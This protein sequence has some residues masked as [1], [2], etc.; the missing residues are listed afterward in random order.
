MCARRTNASSCLKPFEQTEN[1]HISRELSFEF[2]Y[3][4]M[5]KF[6]F[7]YLAK[8]VVVMPGGFGTLDELFELLTLI[9]TRKI[10]KHLPIVL[11]G[12]RYWSEVIDM[13]ALEKYGTID[14][15][16]L[17]LFFRTDSVDEAFDF[18]TEQLK[19]YSLGSPGATL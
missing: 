14:A 3:F 1:P 9:Q 8:A 19:V 12:S 17:E 4:F 15:A 10:R 16:D 6:W 18:I 5:R 2:H 7:T 13:K 11:F